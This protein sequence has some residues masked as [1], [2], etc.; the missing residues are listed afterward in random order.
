MRRKHFNKNFDEVNRT[1]RVKMHKSGKNWVRTVIS[2]L[3]IFRVFKGGVV[4]ESKVTVETATDNTLNTSSHALLKTL[5][6]AGAVAGGGTLLAQ[7]Q[8]T[9]HADETA[10]ATTVDNTET[11]VNADTV[12]VGGTSTSSEAT[13]D[14]ASLS[15]SVQ[16]SQSESLSVA[17]SSSSSESLSLEA[18]L[19]ASTSS[20]ESLSVIASELVSS[21]LSLSTSASASTAAESSS[22]SSTTATSTT[23]ASTDAKDLLDQNTSE[24]DLLIG[25][26]NKYAATLSDSTAKTTLVNS[27]SQVQAQVTA[28]NALLASVATSQAYEDQRKK[29]GSAVDSMMAALT[30]AGFTGNG[31]AADG[32]SA[33]VAQLDAISVSTSSASGVTI[34]PVITNP[35]GAS[36]TDPTPTTSGYAVDPN[37]SRYT[38]GIWDFTKNDQSF[39]Y[40]ATLSVDRSA[41]TGTSLSNPTVYI[42]IVNKATGQEVYTTTLNAGDTQK[43]LPSYI[44]G[45]NSDVTNS[46]NYQVASGSRIPGVVTL[47]LINSNMQYETKQIMDVNYPG[48]EGESKPNVQTSVPSRLVTQNTIYKEVDS[49]YTSGTYTPTGNETVLGKYS[50]TGIEGQ[51]YTASGVRSIDGYVLVPATTDRNLTVQRTNGTLGSVGQQYVELGGGANTYYVKR[52][53]EVVNTDGSTITRFYVLDPSQVNN[54]TTADIGTPDV[55]KYTLVYTTPVMKPGAAYVPASTETTTVYSKNGDYYLK[56]SP[57]IQD[58]GIYTNLITGWYSTNETVTYK[59][60]EVS[61]PNGPI[62]EVTLPKRFAGAPAAS[63]TPQGLGNNRYNVIAAAVADDDN[64]I[65]AVSRSFVNDTDASAGVIF[66]GFKGYKSFSNNYSVPTG[67]KAPVDVVYYYR[68]MTVSESTSQSEAFSASDSA[69][70]SASVSQA[71]SLSYSESTSTS[72]V[73][74]A[75]ASVSQSQSASTSLSQSQS[76]ST[77]QVQSES[78]SVS[79]SQSAS[80][81]VSQSQSTSASV[82]ASQS[83]SASV[84]ASES[85]SVSLSQSES[86]SVSTSAS[87]SASVS[88]S[89]SQSVSTS[90][91]ASVSVS[92]S[93]SESTSVSVSASESLSTSLS[94]SVSASVSLSQSESTSVSV[95]TSQSTSASVS[96]SASLSTSIS[97]SESTSVQPSQSVSASVSASASASVSTSQS[98]SASLSASV[99]ASVSASASA[100]ASLSTSLSQSESTSVWPS[101]SASASASESA[102][103]SASLSASES[104]SVSAS[105]SAS[106]SLSASLSSSESESLST[107]LSTS[108]SYWTSSSMHEW[109]EYGRNGRK[110]TLYG[111]DQ[112]GRNRGSRVVTGTLPRTGETAT[113]AASLLLGAAALTSAATLAKKRRKKED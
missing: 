51:N 99:S 67:I 110:R 4:K 34:S 76:T 27:I 81:S 7:T 108:I 106:A 97:Q 40:Y 60:Q 64:G 22:T 11:L 90:V 70:V 104:A 26:A 93:L 83:T 30:A 45:D 88:T 66:K 15:A 42:R 41:I 78:A 2:Y 49:S 48:N 39:G 85:T 1:S 50:Q 32:S 102:S 18:S 77:S 43:T 112:S 96:V 14:Q 52:I 61:D 46:L 54:F 82:S 55:S 62:T 69:S 36:I 103:L 95:S 44:T 25:I 13:V 31:T 5:T 113:S 101:Q 58:N 17:Q 56:V 57:F 29:L 111:W 75:S 9:V 63:L 16:A 71:Q 89:V 92:T 107:S 79:Q 33:I 47:S 28:S 109:D 72:Q 19:T 80:T 8:V 59:T 10:T 38:F 74:S 23:T 105:E 3:N 35:N 86:T 53:T 20:S 21:S 37:T 84:S 98:Q 24:A 100:S 68:K 65:E 12:T 87:Q 94:Q 91:S 6:A 73:Q